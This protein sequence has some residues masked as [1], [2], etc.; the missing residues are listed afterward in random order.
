MHTDS[1]ALQALDTY[2]QVVRQYPELAI[3]NYARIN[4]ALLLYQTGSKSQAILEL[5]DLEA[6]LRG[7]A[8]VH[9]AL[10]AIIYNE[11]PYEIAYAEEQFDLASDFDKRY[12]DVEWVSREK[13]WPPAMIAA[14]DKFVSETV[15]EDAR[16]S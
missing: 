3:T 11:R 13:H 15:L 9:A 7:F 4:R 5:E 6:S 14:L 8:E 1:L 12:L 10:A 16:F 2:T